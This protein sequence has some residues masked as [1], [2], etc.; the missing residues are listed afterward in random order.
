M[1]R[2]GPRRGAGR[3]PSLDILETIDVAGECA[4]RWQALIQGRLEAEQQVHFS[5]S[6]YHATQAKLRAIPVAERLH[7]L[8]SDEGK[9]LLEDVEYSRR[10][11]ADIAPGDEADAPRLITFSVPRPYAAR[12]GIIGDVAAWASARFGKPVSPR[13]VERAWKYLSSVQASEKQ[14]TL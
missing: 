12:T 6:D 1:S 5:K 13:T 14:R 3:K 11:M 4:A 8:S 10:E 2:G 7:F 9:E